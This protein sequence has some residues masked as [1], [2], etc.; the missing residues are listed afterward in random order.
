MIC[1]RPSATAAATFRWSTREGAVKRLVK[2]LKDLIAAADSEG[3]KLAPF[4]G[5]GCPGRLW[6]HGYQTARS[7]Y[8]RRGRARPGDICARGMGTFARG[9][10]VMTARKQLPNRRGNLSFGFV[11]EEHSYRATAGH[12]DDGRLAEI[13]LDVPGKAGTSL[14]ARPADKRLASTIH[15]VDDEI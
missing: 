1:L 9:G 5:I 6:P 8:L 11:F 3:L 14:Q 13:F 7:T 10:N 12:F 2:M 4:I 15:C